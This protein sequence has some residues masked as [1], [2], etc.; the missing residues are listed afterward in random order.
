MAFKSS[1]CHNTPERLS[2]KNILYSQVKRAILVV[3][4]IASNKKSNFKDLICFVFEFLLIFFFF[5]VGKEIKKSTRDKFEK[6]GHREVDVAQ[7]VEWPLL[8]PRS[9]QFESGHWQ[10]LY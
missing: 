2:P 7:L 4:S 5:F 6:G 1:N 8:K 10:N 3:F 9:P